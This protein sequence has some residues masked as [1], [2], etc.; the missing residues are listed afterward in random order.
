MGGHG[1][2]CF[3]LV[4]TLNGFVEGTCDLIFH[5]LA[6]GVGWEYQTAG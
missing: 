4:T 1:V 6:Y 3:F 5:A 2:L